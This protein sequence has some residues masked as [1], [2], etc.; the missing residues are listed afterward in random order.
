MFKIINFFLFF[1]T[2]YTETC[3]LSMKTL[4]KSS[5]ITINL[6]VLSFLIGSSILI[7]KNGGFKKFF[8]SNF[9]NLY[10]LDLK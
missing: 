5:A 7:K 4:K 6:S 2:I 1:I 9:E 3:F 8:K 10:Y